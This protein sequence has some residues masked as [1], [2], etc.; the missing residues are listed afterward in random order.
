MSDDIPRARRRQ[1]EA[2][3]AATEVPAGGAGADAGAVDSARVDES[4]RAGLQ[5]I[6]SQNDI[7][8]VGTRAADGTTESGLNR[9]SDGSRRTSPFDTGRGADAETR[10]TDSLAQRYEPGVDAAHARDSRAAGPA[11]SDGD[12]GSSGERPGGRAAALADRAGSRWALV[13]AAIVGVVAIV[14]F[15]FAVPVAPALA[16]I[17]IA[18]EV[19]LFAVLVASAAGLRS[20]RYRRLSILV[21]TIGMMV[22]A[23]VFAVLLLVVGISR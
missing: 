1:A 21:P 18:L 15:A 5:N 16:W 23:V 7:A 12:P 3:D 17:A 14:L 20:G 22:V 11:A 10:A 19:A 8:G 4:D 6:S 2:A 9:A 13:P